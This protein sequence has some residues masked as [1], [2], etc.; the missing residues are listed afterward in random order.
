M[1][2]DGYRILDLN[3]SKCVFFWIVFVFVLPGVVLSYN[4]RNSILIRYIYI[5]IP[6]GRVCSIEL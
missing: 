5:Y 2:I 3:A 6:P 1:D 4:M